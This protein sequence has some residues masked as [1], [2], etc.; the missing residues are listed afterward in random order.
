[1]IFYHGYAWLKYIECATLEVEQRAAEARFGR[2]VGLELAGKVSFMIELLMALVAYL[3]DR[4]QTK[5][6]QKSS[7]DVTITIIN[8][9]D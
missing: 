6:Q 4:E 1:M 9:K 7:P 2:V 8:I 3:R 5:Q